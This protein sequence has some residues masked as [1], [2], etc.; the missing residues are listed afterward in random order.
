MA[1]LSA[2]LHPSFLSL[3]FLPF[4]FWPLS[5]SPGL[6]VIYKQSDTSN[7]VGGLG[8]KSIKGTDVYMDTV[9]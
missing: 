3:V 9:M 2:A 6:T 5:F 8:L 7:A 4:N 1:P